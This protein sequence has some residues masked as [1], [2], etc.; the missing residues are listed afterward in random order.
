MLTTDDPEL[1]ERALRLRSHGMTSATWE[2]HTGAASSYDV[3]VPGHNFR[4]DE[5]R[6][7]MGRVMLRDLAAGNERRGALAARYRGRLDA[8]DGVL[9]PFADRPDTERSAHHLAVAV[10][11]VRADREA[12]AAELR[13]AG[14]QTSV[15]YRPTHSFSAHAGARADVTVTDALAGRL[16]TLP[17]FPHLEPGQV[18]L[19]CDAVANALAERAS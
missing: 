14:I 7:A 12:V 2:R 1:A 15:H 6:A 13:E 3:T 16:I 8:I 5:A 17:L 10:L 18:D 11:P 4:F 19:V 9:V